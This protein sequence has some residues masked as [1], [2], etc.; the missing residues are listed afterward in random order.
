VED[1]IYTLQRLGL[2]S[3]GAWPSPTP[4]GQCANKLPL[5]VHWAVP[6][7]LS[8]FVGLEDQM[9]LIV[10]LLN[11]GQNTMKEQCMFLIVSLFSEE[12]KRFGKSYKTYKT[13]IISVIKDVVSRFSCIARFCV[14]V[15]LCEQ[16]C[17][18]VCG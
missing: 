2:A 5:E 6:M 10:A 8:A 4:L 17:V 3:Y 12:L 15:C 9:A 1:G 11:P 13:N 7:V 16:N 14:C 18:S